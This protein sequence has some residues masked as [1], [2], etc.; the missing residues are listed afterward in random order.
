MGVCRHA[1]VVMPNLRANANTNHV[2]E[3]VIQPGKGGT[4]L[5]RA[6]N[7][8]IEIESYDRPG[9]R[10]ARCLRARVGQATPGGLTRR[11]L[12][13]GPPPS[14]IVIAR[15]GRPVAILRFSCSRVLCPSTTTL[16]DAGPPSPSPRNCS[17]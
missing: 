3:P 8:S 9:P 13:H 11:A 12:V 7:E 1:D 10:P 2:S 15:T 16:P 4:A 14:E 5:R 6:N 17:N